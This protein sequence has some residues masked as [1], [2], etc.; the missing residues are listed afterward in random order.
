MR[1]PL[2]YVSTLYVSTRRVANVLTPFVLAISLFC[3]GVSARAQQVR[4]PLPKKSKFTPVQQLNRDGVAAL[5]KH[6]IGKAKR[7]FYKAYLIDPNDPFTLNNLG[8]VS[9]LEGS[10]ERAQ[11]YYDQARANTSEAVIDRSTAQEV[12]GK[13]VASV[14]GHTAEGPLKVNE[15]NS[16]AL[17]LLNRDRA[18]EA[19]VL[20]QA[21]LKLDPKNPFTLNNMG[22]AKEKEGELETGIFGEVAEDQLGLAL[23]QVKWHALGFRGAGRQQK[24][25]RERLR[26]NSPSRQKSEPH[27]ALSAH[28]FLQIEC[29]ESHDHRHDRES[30]REFV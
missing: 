8:Y 10:L 3:G 24:N 12:Q 22:F 26:E 25:E 27:S 21:A 11:R 19:D 30:H 16:E 18:P 5:K 6:D 29:A 13:T 1:S 28:D 20:L 14:A 9:E 7:F 15:L 23:R 4:I 17:G 2:V